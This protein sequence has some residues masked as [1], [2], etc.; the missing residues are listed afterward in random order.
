MADLANALVERDAE[1]TLIAGR[2]VVREKPLSAAVKIR[3]IARYYR[4]NRFL[5]LLTWI[6]GFLQLLFIVKTSH[7]KDHLLIISNP[8]IAILLPLFCRNSFSLFIFDVY[9]DAIALMG[10]VSE[11]S[12]LYRL[13]GRANKMIF[14][15]AKHIFT[16]TETMAELLKQYCPAREIKII[17]VWSNNE[18]FRPIAKEANPFVAEHNLQNRFV[19]LYSGNLGT[20]HDA[21]IIP[22]IAA[23]VKNKNTHFLIIGDGAGKREI[24]EEI[25]RLHLTN[26]TM[27]PLQPVEVIPYSFASADLAIVSLSSRASSLSLPSKTFNFMSA[28]LPLLCI[29]EKESELARIVTKYNNGKC[30][31]HSQVTE[32][33]VFIDEIAE[34]PDVLSIYRANSL[35]ASAD[36]TAKN[37]HIIAEEV[38]KAASN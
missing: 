4:T 19:V 17:P 9:P 27:L 18:F 32:M 36:F 8:P 23:K 10:V 13:W 35:K 11:N 33:A 16:L 12:F 14:N 7:R 34:N 21:G 31:I 24:A 28:G 38:I 1:V 6:T 3:R 26:C 29:A 20:A 37:A 30:F 2:L 22:Q 5:R 15:R 25:K